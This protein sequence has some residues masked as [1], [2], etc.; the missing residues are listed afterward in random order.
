MPADALACIDDLELPRAP[1]DVKH[2]SYLKYCGAPKWRSVLGNFSQMVLPKKQHGWLSLSGACAFWGKL[3]YLQLELLCLQ[4]SFFA[5][6]SSRPFSDDFPTAS[7]K[8]PTVSEKAK[9]VS[10]KAKIASK[11]APIVSEQAKIVNC[12]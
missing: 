3:F 6:S 9:N 4:L 1:E 2:V 7:K 10:K 5:W 8:A 11:K 12:K